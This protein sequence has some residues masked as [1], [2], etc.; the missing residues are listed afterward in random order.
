[1]TAIYEY[2]KSAWNMAFGGGQPPQPKPA[3]IQ[4][5]ALPEALKDHASLAVCAGVS[6]MREPRF[7]LL[8]SATSLCMNAVA[9]G[10]LSSQFRP[11]A[12]RAVSVLKPMLDTPMSTAD[13]I[14]L[15]SLMAFDEFSPYA[16]FFVGVQ[17]GLLGMNRY[18][19]L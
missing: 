5:M 10:Q 17:A 1:M 6:L 19:V 13:V 3:E 12:E 8:G 15:I 14:M 4:P 18:G 11:L 16:C 9:K 2:G 7:L